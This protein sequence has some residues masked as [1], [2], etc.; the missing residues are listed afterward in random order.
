MIWFVVPDQLFPVFKYLFKASTRK[1]THFSQYIFVR[2]TYRCTWKCSRD[3]RS[4]QPR[5]WSSKSQKS[6][7]QDANFY[8]RIFIH[9]N[10]PKPISWPDDGLRLCVLSTIED[11]KLNV[12]KQRKENKTKTW[13]DKTTRN[14]ITFVYNFLIWYL[15]VWTFHLSP[16]LVS[17]GNFAGVCL[18]RSWNEWLIDEDDRTRDCCD[19][20]ENR[21]S[22]LERQRQAGRHVQLLIF[23]Q[24]SR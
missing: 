13:T 8:T 3:Q 21:Y 7:R 20:N 1:Q 9:V 10:K 2:K 14:W 6:L 17:P 22:I 5:S 12:D 16:C 15:S 11:S 24:L 19:L 23:F 18:E 4:Q